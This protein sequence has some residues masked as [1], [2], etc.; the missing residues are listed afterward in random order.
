MKFAVCVLSL[1]YT[2]LA[3]ITLYDSVT[4]DFTETT[5][6]VA[7]ELIDKGLVKGVKWDK[8]KECFMPDKDFNM[9]DILVKT[10]VGKYRPLLKDIPGEPVNSTYSVVRVI[11]VEAGKLYEV[12]SNKCQRIKLTEEQLRGLNAI[13]NVSG[14]F[15]SDKEES[16]IKVCDGVVIE[17][18]TSAGKAEPETAGEN[19]TTVEPETAGETTESSE[20]VLEAPTEPK[21]EPVEEPTTMEQIFSGLGDNTETEEPKQE[22][23]GRSGKKKAD[24]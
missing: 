7:R 12:I 1:G 14:V 3:G 11:T 6:R 9:Q 19:E 24:K 20:T 21:E 2:R 17:D 4:R 5:P 23:K 22:K 10:G 15:I 13:G 18:R 8:E 16:E